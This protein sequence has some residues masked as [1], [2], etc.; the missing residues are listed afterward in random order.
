MV[1]RA[2]RAEGAAADAVCI[3]A[4]LRKEGEEDT[5]LL[6]G[7]RCVALHC[8]VPLHSFNP[9]VHHATDGDSAQAELFFATNLSL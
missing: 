5:M 8:V 1:G 3:F 4:T 2:T 7:A 9:R 6:A